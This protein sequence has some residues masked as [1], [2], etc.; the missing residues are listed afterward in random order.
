MQPK[1]FY[2]KNEECG[3]NEKDED[4]PE[5][6]MP[7]LTLHNFEKAK[8]KILATDPNLEMSVTI[9]QG[10]EKMPSLF[11][12]LYGYKKKLD[13]VKTTLDKFL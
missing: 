3:C 7:V 4:V 6:E 13:T 8:N 9:F 11:Y 12:K 5:E 10:L 1:V 2:V